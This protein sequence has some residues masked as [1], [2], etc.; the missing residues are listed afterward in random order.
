MSSL[1]F[2]TFQVGKQV[3]LRKPFLVFNKAKRVVFL[4]VA[5]A[6]GLC[7]CGCVCFCSSEIGTRGRVEV[8]LGLVDLF[9]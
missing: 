4:Q 6:V 5:T 7:E 8:E 3:R 1:F 9:G 2:I